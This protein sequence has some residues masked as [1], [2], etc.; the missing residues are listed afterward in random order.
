MRIR[1]LSLLPLLFLA[2]ACSGVT[3]RLLT[4]TPT[5]FVFPTQVT[6]QINSLTEPQ[7]Q[8][9]E[10]T[11]TAF[12]NASHV[13]RLADGAYK[14]GAP[15]YADVRLLEQISFG[16][17]N[18]DGVPDA[19]VLLAENF[20][21]SG[22]FVWLAAVL[23][24]NGKPHHIASSMID[25]RA[26]INTLEIRNGNIFLDAVVHGPNDP[27]CCPAFKVTRTFRLMDSLMVLV[28][29]TSQTPTGVE[30]A[31]LIESPQVGQQVSGALTING[32]VTVSPFEN[33]LRLRIYNEQ[34]NEL[35]TAPFTIN[36]SELGAAADFD[37]TLDLAAYAPGLI[38]IEIADLSAADGSVLA[39]ASVE[40]VI[41]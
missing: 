10:Y 2:S 40:V 36:V 4:P 22:V 9:A 26:Q 12:D 21:G 31:I 5:A 7:L 33:T 24:E 8:N 3:A 17:L 19:A 25:D 1:T 16:D 15:D 34:G 37:I 13:F 38:T 30:R 18:R 35:Y 11:L 20:G 28:N 23:N 6:P 14:S 29:A 32:H 27:G 39:L 41:P